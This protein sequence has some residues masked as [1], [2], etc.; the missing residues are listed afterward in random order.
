[1]R[2]SCSGRPLTASTHT[3]YKGTMTIK[4]RV[5]TR[6]DVDRDTE[7]TAQVGAYVRAVGEDLGT[8]IVISVGESDVLNE[9]NN[10]VHYQRVYLVHWLDMNEGT[11]YALRTEASIALSS[12]GVKKFATIE[13]AD[14]WME[15]QLNPGHW[16]AAAQDATD[17]A[18][19]MDV[20]LRKMLEAGEGDQ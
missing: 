5:D 12:R 14:E 11:A 6:F 1:M 19:D 20:E 15:K 13:E 16:T 4:P 2:S 18:S 17:S 9:K 3:V 7:R 10:Q 8:G